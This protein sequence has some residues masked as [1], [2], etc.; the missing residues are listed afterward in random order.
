MKLQP[1]KQEFNFLSNFFE[2]FLWCFSEKGGVQRV[3]QCGTIQNSTY[4]STS[5]KQLIAPFPR[6]NFIS[7]V[8][9]GRN[10]LLRRIKD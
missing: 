5:F 4:F 9:L 8:I 6:I 2:F 3:E 10:I 1:F 7:T